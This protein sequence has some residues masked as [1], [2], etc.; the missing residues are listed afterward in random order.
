MNDARCAP[1][2]ERPR[3]RMYR[4]GLGDCFLL[5]FPRPRGRPFHV[6]IDSG[7]I[8]GTPGSADRMRAVAEDIER[9][10]G[11]E[12]DVL[13]V[14]HEHWDHVSGFAEA[15][16]VWL[17]MAIREIWLA[18][19]ED[20]GDALASRLRDE[21]E[22][23]RLELTRA[24]A[25]LGPGTSLRLDAVR[26]GRIHALLE[27]EGI[28]PAAAAARVTTREALDSIAAHARKRVF[29]KPGGSIPPSRAG[30]VRVYVLGPPHDERQIR[31]SDPSPSNPEV[32]TDPAHAFAF[33]G[34]DSRPAPDADAPFAAET[35]LPVTTPEAYDELLRTHL[36]DVV[37]DEPDP[38]WRRL[39]S[40]DLAAI[41]R[42]A[43]ALDGDTNNTSLALAFELADG[44]TL[45]F[46]ADAQVGNCLS[47]H[48][49]AWRVGGRTIRAA[50]L[51][52]RTVLYKV[53]HHA[54]HNATLREKGLELM[55]HRDLVALVPVDLAAA[56]RRRWNMPF[57]PL[58]ARL[59]ERTRGRVLLAD[60]L[61]PAPD[62]GSLA[63]LTPAER[64]Q[65]AR[66]VRVTSL[67]ID[68]HL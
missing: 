40:E 34:S 57:P 30:G 29:L 2:G 1:A 26:F 9:E 64:D 52:A 63:R 10:T 27:F 65:F 28:H 23:R 15:R 60:P 62:P 39:P 24:L 38:D 35:G 51:L 6:V 55:T 17:R 8:L 36:P 7:V 59:I 58:H 33:H 66:D 20:P 5:R 4:Q 61:V 37:K 46:P 12:I 22:Q 68:V 45:L 18:W 3:V 44:R 54:S 41:E 11:G 25:A 16:E 13:V 67:A 32:Y 47:W 19:T 42:L 48:D 43:V 56:R 21:R 31:R 50:D 14:T 49:H 53:G